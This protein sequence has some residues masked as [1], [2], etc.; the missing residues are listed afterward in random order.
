[1]IYF[2]FAQIEKVCK[3]PGM[4]QIVLFYLEAKEGQIKYIG[5]IFVYLL[6]IYIYTYTYIYVKEMFVFISDMFIHVITIY[7]IPFSYAS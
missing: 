2:I 4:P 5:K 1:M 6:N 3:R 7:F